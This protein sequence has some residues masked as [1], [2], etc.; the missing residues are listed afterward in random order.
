MDLTYGHFVLSFSFP[1]RSD[2][3]LLGSLGPALFLKSQKGEKWKHVAGWWCHP[4]ATGTLTMRSVRLRSSSSSFL[5]FSKW[6]SISVW[7]SVRS[8]SM[9][10]RWMSWD[11]AHLWPV[12]QSITRGLRNGAPIWVSSSKKAINKINSRQS[13]LFPHLGFWGQPYREQ[14]QAWPQIITLHK[15]WNI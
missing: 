12:G 10:L 1:L 6:S 2:L 15:M 3:H 9:R 13:P 4:E 14:N 7:S 11:D 8:F 5:R